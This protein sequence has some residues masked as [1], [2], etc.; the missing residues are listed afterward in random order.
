MR[1][2]TA[3]GP[4][5]PGRSSLP[6]RVG[7]APRRRKVQF[8]DQ[9]PGWDFTTSDIGKFKLTPSRSRYASGAFTARP[10]RAPR[11][12]LPVLPL[13]AR[14]PTQPF[15]SRLAPRDAQ[16][17]N[18]STTETTPPLLAQAKKQLFQSKNLAK[19]RAASPVRA[20]GASP[21]A[22][23]PATPTACSTR[24]TSKAQ[25]RRAA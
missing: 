20:P 5:R 16:T 6:E 21:S 8:D 15:L 24:R 9:R 2:K 18:P 17:L 3:G 25:T 12:S 13:L 14:V 11:P 1:V 4:R 22:P 23:V 19:A 10:V 7:V